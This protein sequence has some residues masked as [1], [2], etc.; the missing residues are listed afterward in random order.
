MTTE[1]GLIKE[2]EAHMMAI[3]QAGRALR[4][5]PLEKLLNTVLRAQSV[6]MFTDPTLCRAALADGRLH[7]QENVIRAAMRLA[8][9]AE[10]KP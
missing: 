7:R 9:A 10:A 2:Y 8:D 5:L 6:G 4:G 1:E 3:I